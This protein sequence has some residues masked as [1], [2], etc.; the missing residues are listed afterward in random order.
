MNAAVGISILPLLRRLLDGLSL[1]RRREQ[2]QDGVEPREVDRG[3]RLYFLRATELAFVHLRDARDRKTAREAHAFAARDE[4]IADLDEIARVDCF[5]VAR[6]ARRVARA[7]HEAAR[8]GALVLD[9]DDERRVDRE[10]YVGFVARDVED[11][12]DDAV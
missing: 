2:N 8:F 11:H 5:D 3:C 9:V 12:A 10:L 7:A 4:E 6:V 1:A